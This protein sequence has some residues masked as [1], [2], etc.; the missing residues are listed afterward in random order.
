MTSLRFILLSLFLGS[1]LFCTIKAQETENVEPDSITFNK[2]N[3]TQYGIFAHYQRGFLFAD[4][5]ELPGYPS[6]CPQ[7][8]GGSGNGFDI[9]FLYE[10]PFDQ[11]YFLSTRLDFNYTSS[12][13]TSSE[14]TL[15]GYNGREYKGSFDHIIS[16][17]FVGIEAQAYYGARFNDRFLLFGGLGFNY[18]L[19]G[20]FDQ[21]EKLS[22]PANFGTFENGKRTRNE[23]TGEPIPDLLGFDIHLGIGA[24]YEFPMN[25]KRTVR[26]APELFFNYSLTPYVKN[27]SWSGA[28]IK[29][30]VALKFSEKKEFP[31]SIALSDVDAV[32]IDHFTTTCS[33][34][35]TQMNKKEITI[36]PEAETTIGLAKWDLVLKA[37]NR[38]LKSFTGSKLPDE[39]TYTFDSDT[40]LIQD[41]TDSI[42][43][44]FTVLDNDDKT[45]SIEK[46]FGIN[47]KNHNFSVS[48]ESDYVSGIGS[49]TSEA[50]VKIERTIST[51]MRPLLNYVFYDYK[52][53]RLPQRYIRLSKKA[54]NEFDLIDLHNE[55]ALTS[56]YHILNIV[57]RRMTDNPA[58]VITLAG[59]NSG[60]GDEK[61][62]IELSL[63]RADNVRA[64]L[65]DV[66][67]IPQ[68]RMKVSPNI[69]TDGAPRK[70][71]MAGRERDFKQADEENRRVEIIPDPEYMSII[72]P[73]ITTDTFYIAQI[74]RVYLYPKVQSS[75]GIQSWN[76]SI[77]RDG[78]E[79]QS[80]S[81]KD[82]VPNKILIDV[83]NNIDDYIK[84]QNDLHYR[85]AF[86]NSKSMECGFEGDIP[87]RFT[88]K[89]STL[90]KFSLILFEFNSSDV[91]ARNEEIVN[92]IRER[93]QDGAVVSIT[94]YTDMLGD[95]PGNQLLSKKRAISTCDKLFGF[96]SKKLAD[97][98]MNEISTNDVILKK[99][100]SFDSPSGKKSIFFNVKGLG[101]DEPLL[102]DNETPEGRFYCR[103]VTVEVWN[104]MTQFNK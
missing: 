76:C 85:F 72:E 33:G 64:Y 18:F 39:L 46:S 19:K 93:I 35:W 68:A 36:Y 70:P 52:Q 92:I 74:G 55:K 79:I 26:L 103:T 101:E 77:T 9:G 88:T 23:I 34:S 63:A 20:T 45:E 62:D 29:A 99:L 57:G 100:L 102:Y 21:A 73:V 49:A 96:E 75:F 81:G 11:T 1:C 28:W 44:K 97:F 58:A 51:N 32:L 65:R 67:K 69:P 60:T 2:W 41:I 17:Y 48:V 80:F 25:K 43:Y 82:S 71:S 4:F 90:D 61:G 24:S 14:P 94:G 13:L 66:W 15:V 7:Y 104:P 84:N 27:I 37:N 56:Y 12:E 42:N 38:V 10:S 50:A 40:T 5:K 98:D 47:H 91:K 30:G 54:A 6:C 86:N 83:D 16:S 87:I 53:S 59:C 95:R 31:L 78:E 89:D 22:E 8:S 3:V